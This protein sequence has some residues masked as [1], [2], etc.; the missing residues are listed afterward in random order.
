MNFQAPFEISGTTTAQIAVRYKGVA[1]NLIAL[2]VTATS[3][4]LYRGAFH[5]DGAVV[6]TANPARPGEVIIFFAT[7]H[8]IIEPTIASGQVATGTTFRPVADVRLN[9]GGQEV[10]L[11]YAGLAPGTIGLLQINA[12]M[13]NSIAAGDWPVALMIGGGPAGEGLS[14][15][16]R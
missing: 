7:G 13:P 6:G 8:G 16:V 3:P 12:Q 1:G 10:S 2:P 5:A 15:P 14:I 4:N 11:L 9:V